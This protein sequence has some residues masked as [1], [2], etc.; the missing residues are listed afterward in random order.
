MAGFPFRIAESAFASRP[1]SK[2]SR[3]RCCT[4]SSQ[5]SFS[6]LARCVHSVF[7]SSC[8]SSKSHSFPHVVSATHVASLPPDLFQN[9]SGYHIEILG[10][11]QIICHALIYNE[12]GAVGKTFNEGAD[13]IFALLL[14]SCP[15][16]R[17]Q[18]PC[19]FLQ[20][21]PDRVLNWISLQ[22]GHFVSSLCTFGSERDP[23]WI[24]S[25]SH[26]VSTSL[27]SL[28]MSLL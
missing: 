17:H 18:Y 13:L 1:I 15:F 22:L 20:V 2:S 8:I 26:M 24:G 10:I 5:N 12:R 9:T 4:R 16:R 7:A 25:G 27:A 3:H 11:G 21:V 23:T 28:F 19:P 6:Y 14:L